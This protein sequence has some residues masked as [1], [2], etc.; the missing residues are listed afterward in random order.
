M[1][2]HLPLVQIPVQQSLGMP[3]ASP[4]ILQL[5]HV[6]PVQMPL[7]QLLGPLQIS[8]TGLQAAQ[9][10]SN[11]PPAAQ[12]PATAQ[13]PLLP[14]LSLDFLP[15]QSVA[16]QEQVAG[17]CGSGD[18][19]RPRPRDPGLLRRDWVQ[20]QCCLRTI[21]AASRGPGR[22][23]MG[24]THRSRSP[25]PCHRT[26]RSTASCTPVHSA[27]GQRPCRCR[28]G[29]SCSRL[30]ASGPGRARASPVDRLSSYG[31][32]LSAPRIRRRRA[33]RIYPQRL[34]GSR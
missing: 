16:P 2:P 27:C 3:Q 21:P 33:E 10:H 14:H 28:A 15:M 17:C 11:P 23:P 26:C 19:P 1:Q 6:P 4:S 34:G 30:R 8:P 9:V 22:R 13:W 18:R 25:R 12:T 5:T 29:A 7:Q 24:S 31:C 20:V 32:L